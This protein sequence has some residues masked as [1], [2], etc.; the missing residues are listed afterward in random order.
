MWHPTGRGDSLQRLRD[1][2]RS[3]DRTA[4]VD[5]LRGDWQAAQEPRV[6]RIDLD[7]HMVLRDG[8]VDRNAMADAIVEAVSEAAD[9]DLEVHPPMTTPRWR[10][11][12]WRGWSA[13]GEASTGSSSWTVRGEAGGMVPTAPAPTSTEVVVSTLGQLPQVYQGAA[14]TVGATYAGAL[15]E[16]RTDLETQREDARL[17]RSQNMELFDRLMALHESTMAARIAEAE[18][19]VAQRLE[20]VERIEAQARGEDRRAMVEALIGQLGDVAGT[21]L[22]HLLGVGP[23]ALG[24]LGALLGHPRIVAALER[25]EIAALLEDPDALADLLEMLPP[26]ADSAVSCPSE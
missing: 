11:Y 18:R 6:V 19:R 16:L 24:P 25:P 7:D 5:L 8:L 15:G 13:K 26:T 12:R 2:V 20:E 23:E 17:L 14:E 9:A 22:P 4:Y 10:R 1:L 3:C 21:I